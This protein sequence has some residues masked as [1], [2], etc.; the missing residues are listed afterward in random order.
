MNCMP[1]EIVLLAY[2]LLRGYKVPIT[3]LH[4][5]LMTSW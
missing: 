3:M 2:Y 4:L 5:T 1:N